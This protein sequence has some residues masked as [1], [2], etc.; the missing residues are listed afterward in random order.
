VTP[1]PPLTSERPTKSSP[2]LFR[3]PLS[4]Y[5][6]DVDDAGPPPLISQDEIKISQNELLGK[7]SYGSVYKGLLRGTV[8]AIKELKTKYENIEQFKSEIS[9]MTRIRHPNIILFLGACYDP[10]YIVTEILSGGDLLNLIMNNKQLIQDKKEV[11]MNNL[12]KIALDIARGMAWLHMS[13]PP[14]IHKDLKPSNIMIDANG[15]AKI[16]DFGLSEVQKEKEMQ[17]IQGAGSLTW[18]SPEM[19]IGKNYTEKIDNY[20]YGIILWQLFTHSPEVYDLSRY[21]AFSPIVAKEKFTSDIVYYNMRPTIPSQFLANHG[22]LCKIM[23]ESWDKEPSKRPSFAMVIESL[24]PCLLGYSLNDDCTGITMWSRYFKDRTTVSI[25]EFITAL[26]KVVIGT[27]PP[28]PDDETFIYLKCVE[29]VINPPGSYCEEVT[30]DRFGLFIHWYGPL[31]PT[32]GENVFQKLE[33]LLKAEW[34]HGEI[35]AHAAEDLLRSKNAGGDYLLR[36]SLNHQAPFTMSRIVNNSLVHY[37]ILY[38]RSSGL[39]K[40]QYQ[41]KKRL[42][43]KILVKYLGLLCMILLNNLVKYSD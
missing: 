35:S 28:E 10:P 32:H 23:E 18:M 31:L 8:V 42:I 16:I 30:L 9:I 11:P 15:T 2:G 39:Y 17:N 36:C 29:A 13:I 3:Y 40:M 37:R 20:A 12:I 6:C 5:S 34:Y 19:L 33:T 27:K 14:I 24:T 43:M 26:W 7:G 41:T 22:K 21:R 1:D 4:A 25:D 38:N